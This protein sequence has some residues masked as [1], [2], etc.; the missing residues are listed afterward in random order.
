MS[1]NIIKYNTDNITTVCML[2]RSTTD[3]ASCGESRLIVVHTGFDIFVAL[4]WYEYIGRSKKSNPV[5]KFY[6]SGIV[7]DFFH[8]IFKVYR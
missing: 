6:T 1:H 7:A 8:Q 3:I 4:P 5:G 2:S